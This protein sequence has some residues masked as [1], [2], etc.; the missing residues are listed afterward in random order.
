MLVPSP[1]S[2]SD[3]AANGIPSTGLLGCDYF[4]ISW[5]GSPVS[6]ADV[7]L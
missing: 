7:M 2:L 3:N 1:Q 5:Q 6:N 4:V